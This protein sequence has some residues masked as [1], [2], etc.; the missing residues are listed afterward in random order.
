MA[1]LNQGASVT[2]DVKIAE[3]FGEQILTVDVTSLPTGMY[4]VVMTTG[5]TSVAQ[6]FIKK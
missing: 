5:E 6:A 3:N 2:K 4:W 1:Q